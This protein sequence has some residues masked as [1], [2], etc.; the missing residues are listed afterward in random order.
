MNERLCILLVD[1][2]NANTL[3]RQNVSFAEFVSQV[4]GVCMYVHV[5]CNIAVSRE[6]TQRQSVKKNEL[7]VCVCAR[8]CLLADP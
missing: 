2:L 5:Q 1:L 3:N 6:I 4:R 8:V 7:C